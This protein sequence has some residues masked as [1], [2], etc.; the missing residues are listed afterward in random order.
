MQGL[1]HVSCEFGVD[2]DPAHTIHAA[3]LYRSACLWPAAQ[4]APCRR[5]RPSSS[6]KIGNGTS[7]RRADTDGAQ[8]GQLRGAEDPAVCVLDMRPSVLVGGCTTAAPPRSRRLRH[9]PVCPSR[10]IGCVSTPCPADGTDDR[11]ARGERGAEPSMKQP[12]HLAMPGCLPLRGRGCKVP[13]RLPLLCCRVYA[14]R[15]NAAQRSVT[16]RALASP[17]QHS[18]R[19]RQPEDMTQREERGFIAS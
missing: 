17:K 18:L 2:Q 6:S 16:V 13:L 12:G 10:R 19:H 8:D 15:P 14:R 9:Q 3:R 7:S 5:R 4:D 11:A 1:A